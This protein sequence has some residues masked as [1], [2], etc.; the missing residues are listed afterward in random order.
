MIRYHITS[1]YNIDSMFYPTV[2][3]INGTS[4]SLLH[5]LKCNTSK[6]VHYFISCY[7]CIQIQFGETLII[8]CRPYT[9]CSKK[10][11]PKCYK[12]KR[13]KSLLVLHVCALYKD[14]Y[15]I[16]WVQILFNM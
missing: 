5:L 16:Y 9:G 10:T 12:N 14:H 6:N 15:I 1:K 2:T 4:E 13:C 8:V 3:V 11:I 7:N